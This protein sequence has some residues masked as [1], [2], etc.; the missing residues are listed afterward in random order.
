MDLFSIDT[1]GSLN[2]KNDV[3]ESEEEEND[4]ETEDENEDGTLSTHL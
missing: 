4:N 3:S 2:V 1:A